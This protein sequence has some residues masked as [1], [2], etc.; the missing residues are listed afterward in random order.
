[1]LMIMIAKKNRIIMIKMRE[2]LR[3]EE[4]GMRLKIKEKT[5]FMRFTKNKIR[6]ET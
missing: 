5:K 1:M 4:S 3:T 2:K 6:L